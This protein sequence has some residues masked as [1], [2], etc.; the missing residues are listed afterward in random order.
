MVAGFAGGNKG[1]LAPRFP[2]F[3][4]GLGMVELD[5][6]DRLRIVDRVKLS[7]V[8]DVHRFVEAI[9][10]IM[11]HFQFTRPRIALLCASLPRL[12]LI[13]LDGSDGFA[14]P[15]GAAPHL[16]LLRQ[17]QALRQKR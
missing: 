3:A 8:D 1:D 4:I 12:R 13:G 7:P 17:E 14:A 5:G 16:D 15:I 9:E 2:D 10:A 6:C 11:A